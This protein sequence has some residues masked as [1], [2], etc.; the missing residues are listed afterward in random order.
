MPPLEALA[1]GCVVFSSLNHALADYADPGHV[2]HQVGCGS[3]TFDVE[4][5]VSAVA[6]P[7]AWKPS[8]DVLAALLET[9]SEEA[10]LQRWKEVFS[11][12]DALQLH[13]VSDQPLKSKSTL[14]LRCGLWMAHARR[15][16]NRL[17]GWPFG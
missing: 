15:V 17:P 8:R 3:L 6:K 7:K 1:C 4:R 12:L 5:V 13:L 10:L 14:I 11:Q 9:C 16:V 2:L